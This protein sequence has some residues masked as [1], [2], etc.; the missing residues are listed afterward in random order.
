MGQILNG[1][2]RSDTIV[3]VNRRRETEV[4]Q[5]ESG[6]GWLVRLVSRFTGFAFVETVERGLL[7]G[8]LHRLGCLFAISP[9][10]LLVLR[11]SSRGAVEVKRFLSRF[12]L[13][14]THR[15]K[16]R[17]LSG[18]NYFQRINQVGR[19]NV[20]LTSEARFSRWTKCFQTR[21]SLECPTRYK[22]LL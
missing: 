12:G 5:E 7:D 17:R 3:E 2:A 18:A 20:S 11:Y 19:C 8:M 14:A 1:T 4:Q 9:D 13:L 16:S 21:K 6:V 10:R 15:M 22:L